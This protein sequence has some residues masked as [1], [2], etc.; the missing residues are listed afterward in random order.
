MTAQ[1]RLALTRLGVQ[2]Q[3]AGADA[4][5]V[6]APGAEADEGEPTTPRDYDSQLH[7]PTSPPWAPR[8]P[9]RAL[10]RPPPQHEPTTEEEIRS[11]AR[12]RKLCAE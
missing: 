10:W 3:A 12:R 8:K 1:C 9:T 4:A 5:M 11:A 2:G 6:A 7:A